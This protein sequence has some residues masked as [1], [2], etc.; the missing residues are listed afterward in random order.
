[1]RW[2]PALL[3]LLAG[4]AVAGPRVV[5]MNPC[6]DAILVEVA[7]PDQIAAISHY[8]K[9]ARAS[10]IG[11][12][13]AAR[14]AATAGTAEEVA[15]LR[16]DIVMTG[17][18]VA[19][20]TMSALRR[21]GARVMQFGVPDT[22][23]ASRAQ[24][25]EIA[26]AVGQP[27]RGAALNARIGAA[28][29]AARS[30]GAAVPA[31]IWMGGGLVPGRGTLADEMLGM[32]GFA[33]VSADMGLAQWDVLPLERLVV[34]PPRVLLTA[35]AAGDDRMLGHP[36]MK[37]LAGRIAVRDFAPTLLYCG[38]PT[39]IRAMERLAVVRKGLR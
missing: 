20:A 35:T 9:D 38:G 39:I 13:V 30:D 8:S 27:G 17:A 2:L 36:V 14:F 18:H 32:A 28:V 3:L 29:R 7:L 6:V 33:N 34:R 24:V 23:A 19:P 10:S 31:L 4:P 5:S 25:L 22:V 11:P 12:A 1:M 21:L 15:A 16:P 37:P 26:D